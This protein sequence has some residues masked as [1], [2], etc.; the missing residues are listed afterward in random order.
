MTVFDE[1]AFSLAA[2]M[3]LFLADKFIA[4]TFG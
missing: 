4:V 1:I 3:Y 2:A